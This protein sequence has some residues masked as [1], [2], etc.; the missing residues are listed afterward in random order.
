MW[1][2]YL[3]KVINLFKSAAFPYT[4]NKNERT[5]VLIANCSL[6]VYKCRTPL[7]E[8]VLNII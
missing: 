3:Y 2:K 7:M 8:L 1:F 6:R 5:L 4:I